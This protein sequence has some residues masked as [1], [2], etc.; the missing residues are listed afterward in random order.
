MKATS[1]KRSETAYSLIQISSKVFEFKDG[2]LGPVSSLPKISPGS[3]GS[4][5]SVSSEMNID[6]CA[7]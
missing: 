4:T 2:E 1:E 3:K 6:F 5:M 7:S